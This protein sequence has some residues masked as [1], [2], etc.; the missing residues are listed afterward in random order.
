MQ[1]LAWLGAV[2]ALAWVAAYYVYA[3][4]NVAALEG[5]LRA[6]RRVGLALSLAFTIPAVLGTG[7]P[8]GGAGPRGWPLL[9][10]L[11]ATGLARARQWLWLPAAAPARAIALEAERAYPASEPVVVVSGGAALVLAPLARARVARLGEWTVAHCALAGSVAAFGVGASVRP[12]LPLDSGFEMASR[13]RRWDAVDGRARDGGDDLA[14]AG[15][16]LTTLGAWRARF[17]T[18]RLYTAGDSPPTG[19][20][21]LRVPRTRLARGHP[22]PSQLGT[23]RDGRW[24]ALAAPA[25]LDAC[26]S[27]AGAPS[28]D[29]YYLARWAAEVRGLA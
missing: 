5:W 17:P 6:P 18:G 10:A 2:V 15:V 26:P 19:A 27:W 9:I 25:G 4:A 14:R 22:S 13:T 24:E 7:G 11:V 28:D 29:T 3:W 23:V 20:V 16:A 21:R 1:G 8:Y 12:T